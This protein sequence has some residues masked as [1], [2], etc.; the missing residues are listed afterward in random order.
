MS[1]KALE[2]LSFFLQLHYNQVDRV[3]YSLETSSIIAMDSS[4]HSWG[5]TFNNTNFAR[6]VWSNKDKQ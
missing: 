6:G 4:S 5:A 2:D 3:I 1:H